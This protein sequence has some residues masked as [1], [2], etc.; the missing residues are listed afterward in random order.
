VFAVVNDKGIVVQTSRSPGTAA[1]A[2]EQGQAFDVRAYGRLA[3]DH[4]EFK[5]GA[6]TTH[7]WSFE[8][9]LPAKNVV[10]DAPGSRELM[11]TI[12]ERHRKGAPE[13]SSISGIIGYANTGWETASSDELY[14]VLRQRFVGR[15]ELEWFARDPLFEEFLAARA[16]ELA[17]RR[18][19]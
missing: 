13:R 1:D 19:G 14:S 5:G 8:T 9:P 7:W 18:R 2:P 3:S 10:A 17:G 16:K 11:A 12:L 15:Q 6:F 4:D